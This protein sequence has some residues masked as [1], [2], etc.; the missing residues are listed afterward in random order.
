MESTMPVR[1]EADRRHVTEVVKALK[2]DGAS[3]AFTVG[4]AAKRDTN[5][6]CKTERSSH[7]E[8]NRQEL[9]R[10][11]ATMAWTGACRLVG[12]GH[13]HTSL[14]IPRTDAQAQSLSLF[15]LFVLMF[16]FT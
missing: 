11:D 3:P 7:S 1:I 10:R 4:V 5:T 2:V 6:R 9:G 12:Q 16:S 14:H 15:F 8:S 13:H